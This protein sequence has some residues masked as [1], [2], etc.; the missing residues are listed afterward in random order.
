MYLWMLKQL[1]VHYFDTQEK[2]KITLFL[3]KFGTNK[4]HLFFFNLFLT[5]IKDNCNFCKHDSH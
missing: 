2:L 4:K 5:D 1:S 3:G